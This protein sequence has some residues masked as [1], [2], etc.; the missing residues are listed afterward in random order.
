MS[1]FE[2]AF[3]ILAALGHS[4]VAKPEY[5][6]T[7]GYVYRRTS[8]DCIVKLLRVRV[9]KVNCIYQVFNNCTNA[10]YSVYC[11]N[12]VLHF[13]FLQ[14]AFAIIRLSPVL[15]YIYSY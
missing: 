4:Q 14:V 15:R 10:I 2:S 8:F 3:S 1:Y 9:L 6:G 7:Q 12:S 5:Q 13:L 11:C